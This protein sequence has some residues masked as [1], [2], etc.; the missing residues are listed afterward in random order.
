MIGGGLDQW[1]DIINIIMGVISLDLATSAPYLPLSRESVWG[2][3][4][5]LIIDVGVVGIY[6]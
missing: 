5:T 4:R 2:F 3:V 1:S 6:L